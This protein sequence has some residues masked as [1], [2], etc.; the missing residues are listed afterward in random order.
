VEKRLR[1]VAA[2]NRINRPGDGSEA[3]IAARGDDRRHHFVP[4]HPVADSP[5]QLQRCLASLLELVPCVRLRRIEGTAAFKKSRFCSPTTPRHP[6]SSPRIRRWCANSMPRGLVIDY[7]GLADKLA[8]LDSL[9]G[10]DL[11]SIVGNA[12]RAGHSAIKARR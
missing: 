11:G 10:M 3:L 5:A 9:A 8:L 1:R 7:F 2:C 12:P 6:S 4:H